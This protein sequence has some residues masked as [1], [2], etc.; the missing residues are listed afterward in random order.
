MKFPKKLEILPIMR[1]R[2]GIKLE[3]IVINSAAMTPGEKSYTALSLMILCRFLYHSI[4]I[5]PST[6]GI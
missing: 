1:N 3:A 6:Y 5:G 2:T 4:K